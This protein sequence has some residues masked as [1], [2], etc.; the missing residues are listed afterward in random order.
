MKQC[1]K[2]VWHGLT[3][4]PQ[5]LRLAI[6]QPI[7]LVYA[8]L[9]CAIRQAVRIVFEASPYSMKSNLAMLMDS[10]TSIEQVVNFWTNYTYYQ[11]ARIVVLTLIGL[12][13]LACLAHHA[14]HKLKH[15]AHGFKDTLRDVLYKLPKLLVWFTFIIIIYY[16]PM[17][18]LW[19]FLRS[20]PPF[21][22]HIA[23]YCTVIAFVLYMTSFVLPILATEK[24]GIIAAFKR[25]AY[26]ASRFSMA[27]IGI[28]LIFTA[29]MV[30]CNFVKYNMVLIF[31]QHLE[32][33]TY[34]IFY[35][36]YY[37]KRADAY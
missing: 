34:T 4:I 12:F 15:E 31:V 16:Y 32:M 27:F 19:N 3:L 2:S 25:S 7:L 10:Q 11:F 13:F 14:M 21:N 18:I 29:A 5:S 30:V 35:Y 8:T 20:K 6:K 23:F 26:L 1:L 24:T 17:G 9:S 33:L 22:P 36:D 28:F 37:V